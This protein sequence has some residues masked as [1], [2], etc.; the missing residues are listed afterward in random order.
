MAL[1]R[2]TRGRPGVMKLS[3]FEDMC[4]I[5]V[6]DYRVIY[7]IHD[8]RLVVLVVIAT[9]RRESYRGQ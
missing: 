5:R 7:E 8:R 1:S 3:G 4:R 2:K 9:H 6:G